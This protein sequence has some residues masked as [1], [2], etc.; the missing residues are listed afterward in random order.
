VGLPH[1]APETVLGRLLGYTQ[2]LAD[3]LPINSIA[4]AQQYP[5]T[6]R[7]E[8]T[9]YFLQIELQVD[10][11]EPVRSMEPLIHVIRSPDEF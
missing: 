3:R 9:N 1:F 4:P 10:L 7:A 11:F 6:S 5:N 2:L 8:A